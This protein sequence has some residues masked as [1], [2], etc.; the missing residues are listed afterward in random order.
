VIKF[1]INPSLT[2]PIKCVTLII[3]LHSKAKEVAK[4]ALEEFK[5]QQEDV[6]DKAQ[7]VL[8]EAE[9]A[10]KYQEKLE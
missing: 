7:K 5:E 8:E 1:S 3:R 10:Q 9:D 6:E 4:E 2:L